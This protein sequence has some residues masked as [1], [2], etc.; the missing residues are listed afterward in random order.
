MYKCGL[1]RVLARSKKKM[2]PER[3]EEEIVER[4]RDR[5]CAILVTHKVACIKTKTNSLPSS[6]PQ[7]W[8]SH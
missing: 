6:C 5:E 3:E 7:L 1:E 8:G 2:S 4:E